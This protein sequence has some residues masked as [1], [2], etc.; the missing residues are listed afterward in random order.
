MVGLE[1]AIVFSF[2]DAK[3]SLEDAVQT[4]A[5]G[6]RCQNTGKQ[7]AAAILATLGRV[8]LLVA[9]LAVRLRRVLVRGTA[10]A[11]IAG[12]RCE[13]LLGSTVA[14]TVA[15]LGR[16]RAVALLR[17]AVAGLLGSTVSCHGRLVAVSTGLLAVGRRGVLGLVVVVHFRCVDSMRECECGFLVMVDGYRADGRFWFAKDEGGK[18]VEEGRERARG[19]GE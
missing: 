16:R 9:R 5:A 13:A 11:G 12:L 3:H 6:K 1:F 7:A 4:A 15:L 14:G 10:V 18:C 17:R 2:P 19:G 8:G